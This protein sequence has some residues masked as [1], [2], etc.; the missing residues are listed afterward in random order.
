MLTIRRIIHLSTIL[1][2]IAGILL[3]AGCG[4]DSDDPGTLV[5]S[6]GS[7]TVLENDGSLSITVNRVSGSSGT[8]TVDYATQEDTALAGVDYVSALGTLTFNDGVTSQ[9]FSI[10]IIDNAV[11]NADKTFQLE[12][13]NPTG[14]ALLSSP[15]DAG[16]TILDDESL[17]IYDFESLGLGNINGQDNWVEAVTNATIVND[18]LANGTQV[19]RPN[20][21]SGL[22]GDTELTR[23]NDVNFN[24]PAF[25]SGGEA[26]IWFDATGDDN[27]VFALGQDINNDGVL[28]TADDEIGVPFG[29]WER[30]FSIFTGNSLIVRAGVADLGT[31]NLATDWYR[32]RLRIDFGANSGDGSA[33]LAYMNLT[34]GEA[35][36]TDI[37]GL[38]D[39]NLKLVFNGAPDE[40]DWD[41]MFLKLRVDATNIPKVDNLIPNFPINP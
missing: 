9:N 30:Q 22:A 20:V 4:S 11:S 5:L 7:Y 41:A 40:A 16:V 21:I 36:F 25:P 29:I 26:E 10:S 27:A 37:P 13:S 15:S 3:F 38:Q 14:G 35:N 32:M 8:V 6:E 1:G 24:Y 39:L 28:T 34:N 12:L 2:L 19:V 31:N 18:T 23:V 33:S 17:S